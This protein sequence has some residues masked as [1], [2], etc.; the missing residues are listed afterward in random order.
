MRWPEN[1]TWVETDEI[2][3]GNQYE[4]GD[5]IVDNDINSIIEDLKLEDITIEENTIKFKNTITSDKLIKTL[6]NYKI[7]NLLIEE[8]TLEDIFLH[9]YK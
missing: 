8:A 7:D 5:G 9:Y 4:A 6:S 3:N 1:P 2:N